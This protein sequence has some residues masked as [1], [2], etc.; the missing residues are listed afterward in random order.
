M[1]G[2]NLVKVVCTLFVVILLCLTVSC[3]QRG[4]LGDGQTS[5]VNWSDSSFK[6]LQQVR[7]YY[8]NNLHD[9][10]YQQVP[11]DMAFHEFIY[12]HWAFR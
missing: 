11:L 10:L 6:R 1:K 7:Y 12:V 5:S 2:L 3:H 4:R 8:N 9:S